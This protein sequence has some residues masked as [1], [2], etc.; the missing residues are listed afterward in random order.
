MKKVYYAEIGITTVPTIGESIYLTKIEYYRVAGFDSLTSER[1]M[2]IQ[3]KPIL[4]IE[5]IADNMQI[6]WTE[7]EGYVT[8]IINP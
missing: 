2:R 1:R 4:K 7:D 6:I 8:Y 3:T 5:K